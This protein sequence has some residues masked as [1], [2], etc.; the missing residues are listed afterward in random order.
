[1]GT[2]SNLSSI[3]RYYAEKQNSP[4]IDFKEF[5]IWIKKYAEK[6]VE[7]QAE[8]V[9]YLGDPSGTLTAELKG[10]EEKHLAALIESN[11]KKVIVSI[12]FLS[13]KYA[14]RYKEIIK[15][16]TIPYITEYDLP[17]KVPFEILERKKAQEYVTEA[18]QNQ[19]T[20][21]QTVYFL[22]FLREVPAM[23]I[24]ASVPIQK[25]IEISQ[26]KILRMMRK[27][28][29]H[30]YLLKKIRGSNPTREIS[31]KHF[32]TTY[33]NPEYSGFYDFNN[34]DDY[35]LWS[36]LCYLLRV[37]FEK[38]QDRTIEDLNVLQSIQISEAYNSYLKEQMQVSKR[39]E[40]A[41]KALKTNLQQSP[42]FYSSNQI[43]KFHDESGRLLYGQ[44]SEEDLKEFL[45]KETTEAEE[46][47]LPELLVFKVES[48]TK[49]YVYKDNVISLVIRLCN[50]A[51][52]TI[53]SILTEEWYRAMMDYSKLPEMNDD[54]KFEQ[55]LEYLVEEKSPVLYSLL[56]ANFMSFLAYEKYNDEA[57]QTFQIFAD[58][59]LLPYS[60]LLMLKRT[61]ILSEAKAKL[62]FIFSLPILSWLI[63]LFR[64][65]KNKKE[66]ETVNVVVKNPFDEEESGNGSEHKQ[67]Q[68]RQQ[69][70]AEQAIKLSKEMIP[71][72]SSLD[73]ELNYLNKQ[74]NKL[75]TKEASMNLT[76][77]VNS[78]IR[79][80]TRK[81]CRTISA[82]SFTKTRI[83][84]LA[85]TLVKT[86]NLQKIGE[87]KALKE[88]IELYMLRLVSN[89]K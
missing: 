74:W 21:S 23:V 35:Y 85:E 9:K 44:Y 33:I 80:Y 22:E 86:P 76:E 28:D 31:I 43:L 34:D 82:S 55:R 46:K 63:G 13:V 48:G 50:E 78:L 72:G 62:P 77:D 7:E 24:P 64:N 2:S 25:L 5:S 11:N 6:K 40:S 81:V 57:L 26:A 84:N 56:N 16:F 29:Y 10:L 79:D 32:F 51:H 45:Q 65:K 38:L 37:D 71:E 60:G 67:Q 19:N 8:L 70:L 12:A 58:D 88:Y 17:K 73:R 18:I 89:S 41:L 36:Q 39:R 83:E 75:I 53:E 66:K 49:Y 69:S 15:D 42:Y 14:E 4:F 1:M 61:N 59:K 87:E 27:E 3:I 52:G 68:T 47:R 54:E 30:D 20:K